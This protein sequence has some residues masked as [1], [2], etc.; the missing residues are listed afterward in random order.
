MRIFR[1]PI[2]NFVLFCSQLCQNI[3]VFK[4]KILVGHYWGDTIVPPY[5]F[6]LQN[7]N[8]S[9]IVLMIDR[10]IMYNIRKVKVVLKHT[11]FVYLTSTYIY[12]ACTI[13]T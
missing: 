7:L 9:A 5:R 1:A 6:F 8:I 12:T 2:L 13:H 4:Q 3:E 11:K 10:R